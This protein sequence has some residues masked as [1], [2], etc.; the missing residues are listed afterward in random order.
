MA[1][2]NVRDVQ[3][4]ELTSFFLPTADPLWRQPFEG[5]RVEVRVW[6]KPKTPVWRAWTRVTVSDLDIN[7]AALDLSGK[8]Q[9]QELADVLDKL[10]AC[11]DVTQQALLDLGFHF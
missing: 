9:G 8:D 4:T 6:R 7:G 2:R 10:R 3:P 11:P 5:G 1:K